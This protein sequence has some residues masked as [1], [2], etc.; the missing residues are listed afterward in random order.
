MA[1]QSCG[2]RRE[3]LR[4]IQRTG[5]GRITTA[6]LTQRFAEI[7]RRDAFL[8]LFQH[9]KRKPQAIY[10]L[11]QHK[12][13]LPAERER[14]LIHDGIREGYITRE[15]V[16]NYRLAQTADDL[17]QFPTG[18]TPQEA[19]FVQVVTEFAEAMEALTLANGIPSRENCERAAKE[20]R[21]AL[22]VGELHVAAIEQ[23]IRA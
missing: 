12:T 7:A 19:M 16:V 23:R 13:K 10:D 1:T 9:A 8:A 6:P 11:Q 22:L 15:Q 21:E 18:Y 20:T 4:T 17:G 2:Q 3:T 14:E 5:I